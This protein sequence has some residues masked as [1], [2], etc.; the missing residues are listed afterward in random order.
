MSRQAPDIVQNNDGSVAVN[1][2]PT[3]PG[4]HEVSITYNEQTVEGT[5]FRCHVD[6]LGSG[7]VTAFGDGLS[8]GFS[9]K[10]ANFTIVGGKDV[11]MKIE[12]PNKADIKKKEV[13]GNNVNVTYV[14][15]SPGEYLVHLTYKGKPIHGSPFSAKVTGEGRKRSQ[16]SLVATSEMSLGGH[17]VDLAHMVGTLKC[18]NGTHELAM[19]K[20]MND[21]TLG[22][23]SFCPKTKGVYSV[24]VTQDGRAISGS[25][26]KIN[27]TESQVTSA[28]KVK[29]SGN[30]VK[31]AEANTWNEF[32]LDIADAGHGAI[33]ISVEG[34]H[35]SDIS[36]VAKDNTTY[37]I[38]YKPHEPG[39]YLLNVRFAD[40]HVTGS[41]FMLNVGGKPSG[42]VRE[43][44]TQ[45]I[46]DAELAQP[47]KTCEFQLKIPGTNPLDME[48]VI[49]SPDGKSE[50]CAIMDLDDSLYDI[51]FKPENEGVH[52]ISLKHKGLHISGSPFQYT[53]GP[54]HAAG[55]H[56]VEIGG[57]GLEKGEVGINNAFNV[58]TREA[59]GGELSVAVE[60][61]S[62]AEIKVVDRGHGYTTVSYV[63]SKPGD[64]GVHVKYNDTH[65][66]DSPAKVYIAPESGDAKKVCVQ[67]LRDRGLDPGKPVTFNVNLC[68][69]KGELKA[70]VDTPDG[71]EQEVFMH[72]IDRELHAIRFIPKENGVYYITVKFNEA[73]IP[74]SPFP[75]LIG[76]LGADPALVQAN[77][78]GLSKG[79]CGKP[80]KF[81]VYTVDA[82]SGIIN[83]SIDG[84]GKVA[85]TCT[86][87]DEG[88]EFQ[89]TPMV[90]G[91]YLIGIKYCNVSLAGLPSV[92][93][94]TGGKGK[95]A[96]QDVIKSGLVIETVE[97]KPGQAATKRF[98][99][100]ADKVVAAGNG[101]K[102]TF[103]GRPAIFTL[104]IKDAGQALLSIGVIGP[105][106]LPMDELVYRKSRN[107]VY[108]VSFKPT[109]KG[110]H[111]VFVRWGNDDIPG[112]PF[113]VQ[114]A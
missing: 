19:L 113:T 94:I 84:P 3:A 101:L 77:G 81:T 112:S 41:P 5:P 65:V 76:K 93:V 26:F 79:V 99:G 91:E 28:G 68:G 9:G 56:K 55:P 109:A 33:T 17:E 48:A 40:D 53:V 71:Q 32:E 38:K 39:M 97:K 11:D 107:T 2:H 86:E 14:P 90:P 34:P 78:D 54:M 13:K 31:E 15:M 36:H 27:V 103:L 108:Q 6:K 63:V 62:K 70:H 43:T 46:K 29:I 1:Y 104:D 100:D 35:R 59:G 18:P 22:M 66:P 98:H 106:G 61:P 16:L 75:M 25:P 30:G 8:Q 37:A 80:C 10:E 73:H 82:G 52:T 110:D 87:V 85:V 57:P 21:G 24:D 58:Y 83:V 4:A 88:Y 74:G 51:K 69:A 45:T 64:Y 49:T 72:E 50:L 42:R 47:G 12:G 105:N 20:K 67:G 102:K 7:F 96:S 60:G 44:V 23:S 114:V 95:P 89:Y 111:Q 92:A